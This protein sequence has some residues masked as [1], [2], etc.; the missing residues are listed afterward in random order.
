M[1]LIV[2][3][4]DWTTKS[5]NELSSYERKLRQHCAL[6]HSNLRQ[7]SRS[8]QLVMFLIQCLLLVRLFSFRPQREL[9]LVKVVSPFC[10][11]FK[12]SAWSFTH[13]SPLSLES[14]WDKFIQSFCNE[15]SLVKHQYVSQAFHEIVQ[16]S[17]LRL[18]DFHPDERRFLPQ[19]GRC[20]V[21]L[22]QLLSTLLVPDRPIDPAA[23]EGCSHQFHDSQQALLSSQIAMHVRLEMRNSG[24]ATNRTIEFL[25][26]ERQRMFTSGQRPEPRGL[27]N[28]VSRLHSYWAEVDQLFKLVLTPDKVDAFVTCSSTFDASMIQREN[29]IQESLTAFCQRLGTVYPE[30]SDLSH[31]LQLGLQFMKLGLRLTVVAVPDSNDLSVDDH[32]ISSIAAF[33]TV[34]AVEELLI[35]NIS[36]DTRSRTFEI[37]LTRIASVAFGSAIGISIDCQVHALGGLYEQAFGLWIV[38]RARNAEQ[39][40]EAQSLYRSKVSSSDG[41]NDAEME[42]AEFRSLFP[43]YGDVLDEPTVSPSASKAKRLVQPEMATRLLE[44]HQS[45]FAS[46]SHNVQPSPAAWLT[47]S[48]DTILMKAMEDG[49]ARW[50]HCLDNVTLPLQVSLLHERLTSLSTSTHS[51]SH[52]HDFY[53]D[54]NVPEARKFLAVLTGFGERLK[55]LIAE[56]PDQMVLHHLKAR[57]ETALKLG[58]HSPVAKFLA[59]LEQLLIQTEDWEAFANRSNSIKLHQQ[60]FTNLI[61]EW[62]RLE[63][64]GWKDLLEIQAYRFAEGLSEWWFRLYEVCI[65]GALEA[66]QECSGGDDVPITNYLDNLVPLLEAFISQGPL[67][68]FALR[69]RLLQSFENYASVLA[70]H[71]SSFNDTLHRVCRIIHSIRL[72]F[73]QFESRITT[74]LAEQRGALEKDIRGFIKVASWRDINVQ[75]LKQSAQKTHHQLYKSIRKFR[76][77]LRQPVT[78]SLFVPPDFPP[79]ESQV[80]LSIKAF[81][82][83]ASFPALSS[84]WTRPHHLVNLQ[85]TF[86]RFT[87]YIVEDLNPFFQSCSSHHVEALASEVI[88][89]VKTFSESSV[90]VGVDDVRRTKLL[91]NLLQRKRKAWSDTLKELKRSGLPTNV[92]PEILLHQR[93]PRSLREQPILHRMAAVFDPTKLNHHWHRLMGT[94]PLLRS[95]VAGHHSD[96]STREL[97]RGVMF[98]EA[99]LSIALSARTRSVIV[100]SFLSLLKFFFSAFPMTLCHWIS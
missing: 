9:T 18:C 57:C 59:A 64:S 89:T 75:A 44:I 49:V 21:R 78:D 86:R 12:D 33:P 69:L 32:F 29:V 53:T 63:L 66:T 7:P 88:S 70:T 39:E 84:T 5:L 81:S 90:P 42:E 16:P 13:A 73:G 36:G 14:T 72:Y 58:L 80:I 50:S 46:P 15:I 34:K 79:S 96:L 6:I 92:K 83:Q 56:W 94:L 62:R 10:E 82:L 85:A 68:Q 65:H 11:S 3:L 74:S 67:G 98:V 24:N 100:L 51:A 95:S 26:S 30:F 76:D 97:Q 71:Q 2:V 93:D 54:A 91:K 45:L 23:I 28:N 60:A 61:V 99:C 19:L 25:D 47:A 17:L 31:P 37:L 1:S 27:R 43:E 77:V 35:T 55:G 52:P 4:S 38:E 40:R 48:R 20:F 87:T 22:G 8:M 41:M